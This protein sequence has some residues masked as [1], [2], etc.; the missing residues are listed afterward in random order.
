[1][2]VQFL[3]LPCEIWDNGSSR[4]LY[5]IINDKAV[6]VTGSQ[7][8]V[9][10]VDETAVLFALQVSTSDK[11]MGGANITNVGTVDGVDVSALSSSDIWNVHTNHLSSVNLDDTKQIVL[12]DTTLANQTT[13]LAVWGTY[14]GRWWTIKKVDASANTVRVRGQVSDNID[15]AVFITLTNQYD[16]VTIV[17]GTETNTFN[18]V[19]QVP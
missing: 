15:G 11:D 16:S 1:M 18:I 8:M 13:S 5:T 7:T 10:S 6:Q 12:C 9:A 2:S 14:P 4:E 19:A 3:G 17:E